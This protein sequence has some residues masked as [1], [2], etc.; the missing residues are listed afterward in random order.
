[1]LIP[2]GADIIDRGIDVNNTFFYTKT[3]LSNI[4]YLLEGI[5]GSQ[6]LK[7][8]WK[9]VG[10]YSEVGDD[11]ISSD[12]TNFQLWLY[13]GSNDIEVHFGPNS[14]TQPGLSFE[15]ETGSFIGLFPAYDF[16]KDSVLM[17]GIALSGD[18][19]SPDVISTDSLY[20]NFLDGVI[21]NGTIYKFTNNV[22][23]VPSYPSNFIQFSIYPNP[24][25][26]Y[27]KISFDN[28]KQEINTILITNINGQN[29]KEVYFTNDLIDI[30]DLNSG[31]YF[32]EIET[33]AGI[34]TKSLLKQ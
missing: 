32:V 3:S 4:S 17:D 21:P 11:G 7:I 14:I 29:V 1:L 15:G 18:P 33:N 30:S 26:E 20:E 28:K 9:N 16:D 12:F 8:E 25:I 31:I 23:D 5:S 34:L 24:S 6:I 10:F 13:E 19:S 27:F 2:Y 22:V